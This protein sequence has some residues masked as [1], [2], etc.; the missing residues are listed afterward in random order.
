VIIQTARDV[1]GYHGRKVLMPKGSRLICDYE[2]PEDIGSSRLAITCRRV[3]I[4]GHRAEI[5][6]LESLVS[7]V[8]GR[9]GTSGEVDKRFW[10]RYGT[11]FLLT[12]IS[13]AVRFANTFTQTTSE[14]PSPTQQTTEAGSAELSNRLGEI[15]ANVL[16]QTLDLKPIITV[17]QGTRIQIRP[18]TDWYIGALGA[19]A[20]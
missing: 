20:E 14:E 5:R 4:A 13:T 6:D 19:E 7:D 8:Q 1:F 3:L 9:S 12:G 11:A 16:E 2:P 15:S 18:Q 10:E 17:P